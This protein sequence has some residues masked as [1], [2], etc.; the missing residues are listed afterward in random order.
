MWPS[1]L[2]PCVVLLCEPSTCL[3][4][5]EAAMCIINAR[6]SSHRVLHNQRGPV[7]DFG[8]GYFQQ[9]IS[10]QLH[11]LWES[12]EVC[13]CKP[14]WKRRPAKAYLLRNWKPHELIGTRTHLLSKS[15]LSDANQ[16]RSITFSSVPTYIMVRLEWTLLLNLINCFNM[17]T[18]VCNFQVNPLL[19]IAKWCLKYSFD[20]ILYPPSLIYHNDLLFNIEIDLT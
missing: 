14:V 19:T 3:G 17:S 8:N 20:W 1:L 6:V 10:R 13:L 2:R 15:A 11:D 7:P 16:F 5:V 9:P 4:W 12:L 18:L